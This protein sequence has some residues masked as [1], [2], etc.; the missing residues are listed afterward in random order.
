MSAFKEWFWAGGTKAEF[1]EFLAEG[2]K[3]EEGVV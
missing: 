3:G 1:G 2:W